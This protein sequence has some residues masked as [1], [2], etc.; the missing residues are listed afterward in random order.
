MRLPIS[1]LLVAAL[2]ACTRAV[3][4]KTTAPLVTPC[5]ERPIAH[6]ASEPARPETLTDAYVR[7]LH[8]WANALLGVITDDRVRWRGERRCVR[9]LADKGQVR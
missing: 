5:L 6:V 3:P 1:L 4:V 8:G 2:S 7:D 9:E